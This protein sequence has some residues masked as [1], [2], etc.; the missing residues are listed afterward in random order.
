MK[1]TLALV[2]L[3]AVAFATV[4]DAEKCLTCHEG[5]E[6]ISDVKEKAEL[7]CTDCHMP[8]MIRSAAGIE[9]YR[10]GDIRSHLFAINP[11]ASAAQ[12]FT[13]QDGVE[14]SHPYITLDYAC[15][16]CHG[17]TA[18]VQTLQELEST[19]TNYHQ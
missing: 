1:R 6:K 9:A 4:A 12:L 14:R 10:R 18:S 3:G 13:D 8:P 19:A 2:T 16:H 7:S 11:S 17:I 5:I 15:N